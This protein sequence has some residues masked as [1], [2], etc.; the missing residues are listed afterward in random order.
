MNKT[1]GWLIGLSMIATEAGAETLAQRLIGQYQQI[2]RVTCEVSK[3]TESGSRTIRALSRVYYLPNDRIHIDNVRPMKRRYIA[4]GKRLYYYID[5]DPKGFSRPIDELGEDWLIS[6]R[7]VPGTAMDH[8]LKIGSAK[9]TELEPTESFPVRRGY[10]TDTF[11]TVLNLD[12]EDRLAQVEYY[13]TPD[14]KER[15]GVYVYDRFEEVLPE[16]HVP[17]RHI[18][19]LHV[20]GM[21]QTETS[22]F[23][24]YD[25]NEPLPE[26]LF[27]AGLFFEGVE[28]TDSFEAIYGK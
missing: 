2:E 28:F 22:R 6:L 13:R 17:M 10:E 16:V 11:F 5:G 4:D 27:D 12:A 24:H 23:S 14:R 20:Q 15:T 9:E 25:V 7:K 26:H 3:I 8:L 21:E 1:I 19:T 18:G